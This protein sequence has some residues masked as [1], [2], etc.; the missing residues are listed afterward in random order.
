VR[1]AM[2]DSIKG[3][4]NLDSSPLMTMVKEFLDGT[5]TTTHDSKQ[6]DLGMC[7]YKCLD[8]TRP[9]NSI[10]IPRDLV[11]CH[12]INRLNEHLETPC[13]RSIRSYQDHC[14]QYA[15][16]LECAIKSYMICHDLEDYIFDIEAIHHKDGVY[17]LILKNAY[18]G[19]GDLQSDATAEA[20]RDN[21][22]DYASGKDTTDSG[23]EY[24]LGH[25]TVKG[26]GR[27]V[28]DV[29]SID[30]KKVLKKID[31]LVGVTQKFK[32]VLIMAAVAHA[33]DR[34]VEYI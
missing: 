9:P 13:A 19:L 26:S 7:K 33:F 34:S 5:F 1:T 22:L 28:S 12:S 11:R 25:I 20:Q 24:D 23:N 15:M 31:E 32:D 14:C 3:G 30:L 4:H 2:L 21:I 29:T 18:E 6:S 16:K 27:L 10:C 17:G 8:Y